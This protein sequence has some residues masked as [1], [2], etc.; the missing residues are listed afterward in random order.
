[1]RKIKTMGVISGFIFFSFI[2]CVGSS[3]TGGQEAQAG[4]ISFNFTYTSSDTEETDTLGDTTT[5]QMTLQ[6][7]GTEADSYVVTMIKNSPTP[8]QWIIYFCSGGICHP[9]SVTQD[10]VFLNPGAQDLQFLDM[11]SRYVCGEGSVTMRVTSIK[12]PGLT[13]Q[14]TFLLH[15]HTDCIPITNRWGLLILISLLVAAG[16]YLIWKRSKLA[17]A[18]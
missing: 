14:I 16:F 11:T 6:N 8:F 18:T 3:I 10:T 12:S 9:T 1:M 17:C 15:V 7:T 13:K 4:P 5:F 2:F